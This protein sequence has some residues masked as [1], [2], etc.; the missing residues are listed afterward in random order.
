MVGAVSA[1]SA[2]DDIVKSAVTNNEVSHSNTDTVD[3]TK[4]NMDISTDVDDISLY[5]TVNH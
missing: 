2:T 5:S 3:V 4:T 1:T